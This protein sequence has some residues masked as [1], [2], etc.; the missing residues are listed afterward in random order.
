MRCI[1]KTHFHDLQDKYWIILNEC[2]H[3]LSL[4]ISN[5]LLA[6]IIMCVKRT[7]NLIALLMYTLIDNIIKLDNGIKFSFTLL[8]FSNKKTSLTENN[9]LFN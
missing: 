2:Q 7:F 6:Y 4:N 9:F 1:Q 3:L 5:T 8:I